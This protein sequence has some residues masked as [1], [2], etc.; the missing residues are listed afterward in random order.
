MLER[1]YDYFP[2]G[3][4]YDGGTSVGVKQRYTYTGREVNP[5]GAVMY[6]RYREYDPR[7]GRFSARDPVEYFGVV[8]LY[9]YVDSMPGAHTD[10]SGLGAWEKW[11]VLKWIYRFYKAGKIPKACERFRGTVT[12]LDWQECCDAV[13]GVLPFLAQYPCVMGCYAIGVGE[14]RDAL[15]AYYEE[16]ADI[17]SDEAGPDGGDV[18]PGPVVV[19]RPPGD[20]PPPPPPP[21]PP[22]VPPPVPPEGHCPPE[23]PPQTPPGPE[24]GKPPGP[25]DEGGPPECYVH[26][27]IYETI[28]S[29]GCE[30][31]D[32]PGM[33]TNLPGLRGGMSYLELPVEKEC[34]EGWSA[35]GSYAGSACG[36]RKTLAEDRPGECP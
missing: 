20:R 33:L 18:S 22:P 9:S 31:P 8:G 30:K 3:L 6:Y 5:A 26:C 16:F 15:Q 10:P 7:V 11:R 25:P 1:R 21:P 4:P 32:Y 29:G 28:T 14:A 12:F 34:P 17:T 2:F 36:A 13:C 23:Q 35:S 27:C 19:V 24:P